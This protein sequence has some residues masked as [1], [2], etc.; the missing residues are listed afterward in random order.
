L[1]RIIERWK[2]RWIDCGVNLIVRTD[3]WPNATPSGN[4]AFEPL[5]KALRG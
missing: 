5:L 2:S 1:P 4:E 3:N